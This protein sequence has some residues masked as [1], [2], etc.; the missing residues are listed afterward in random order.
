[1]K[2]FNFPIP[3]TK[4]EGLN[5]K[6][7]LNDVNGRRKYFQAKAG[8]E[9]KKIRDYLESGNTFIAYLV[10]I[11]N[12][13]KGTYSKLFMEAI[14]G[15]K[16]RHF[17]QVVYGCEIQSGLDNGGN[18]REEVLEFLH[19][20]YRG[21]NSIE[22]LG[23]AISGRDTANLVTSE[24]VV[25]LIKFEISQYEKK[26]IFIDGFPRAKDQINYSMFLKEL[27]GYRDDPDFLIFI[28]VPEKIVDE[29]IKHRVVCPVCK[30]PRSLRLLPTKFVGYDKRD[31]TFY[32]MCDDPSC[33]K[34]RM[35]AKEGDALGIEPIRE[36][37]ETDREIFEHLLNIRGIP[38]IYLRNFLPIGE[39]DDYVDDYEITPNYH[40]ELDENGEVKVIE[41]PWVV[42]DDKKTPSYS[43]LSAPVVVSLLK[44][45]AKVLNL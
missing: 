40:Y 33:N 30:A 8:Q 7:D 19:N 17:A 29:R 34:A 6:F 42:E 14:G 32:L 41:K 22:E 45:T 25:A 16:V 23:K 28:D 3:K 37:L 2:D 43:L 4:I 12:S 20:K 21:N 36:R 35:V 11:K 10:G 18:K 44:Q 13:G 27:V 5:E 26:A 9:I 39:A 31:K 1:M 15:D 24:L 38:K